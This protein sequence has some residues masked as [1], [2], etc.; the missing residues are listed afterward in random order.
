M[1]QTTNE[2]TFFV[3]SSL[4]C[5]EQISLAHAFSVSQPCDCI[6]RPR[7]ARCSS[8]SLNNFAEGTKLLVHVCSIESDLHFMEIWT[9][10]LWFGHWG[11]GSMS[12]LP[13]LVLKPVTYSPGT[14]M[15]SGSGPPGPP[16]STAVL[17]KGLASHRQVRVCVD[18][19]TGSFLV[20][21]ISSE[22]KSVS[23]PEK[24]HSEK[25]PCLRRV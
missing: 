25:V 6:I 12:D 9:F 1:F 11:S 24:C 19:P 16:L 3:P 18:L 15:S 17:H 23:T 21:A 22:W 14:E 7:N 2:Y 5:L 10:M 8:T 13:S 20:P 4:K